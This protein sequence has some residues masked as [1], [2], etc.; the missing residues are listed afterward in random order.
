GSI[1]YI[2][3]IERINSR[4]CYW[5][6]TKPK[7]VIS[8]FMSVCLSICMFRHHFYSTERELNSSSSIKG[9]P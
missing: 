5:I 6:D 9:S 3:N 1:L 7:Y 4:E 8:F 2:E